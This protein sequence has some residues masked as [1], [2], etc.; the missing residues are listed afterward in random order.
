MFQLYHEIFFLFFFRF[1][2]SLLTWF[3]NHERVWWAHKK[4]S[5]TE[6]VAWMSN[7]QR[8]LGHNAAREKV[9]SPKKKSLSTWTVKFIAH[10]NAK[11]NY[12]VL[13]SFFFHS[14]LDNKLQNVWCSCM[15]CI[16]T[17]AHSRDDMSSSWTLNLVHSIYSLQPVP[18]SRF[19]TILLSRL[20]LINLLNF[21]KNS[22]ILCI[23]MQ[24][25]SPTTLLMG[26]GED[27]VRRASRRWCF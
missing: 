9:Y 21:I 12:Y 4:I 16:S 19:H 6:W 20:S 26:S 22:Y 5:S 1:S 27:S 8:S 2:N 23:S 13:H 10:F 14:Y 7:E 25:I 24:S 15:C 18:A 11:E 17:G 3:L